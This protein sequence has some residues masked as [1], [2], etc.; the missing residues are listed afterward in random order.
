[1]EVGGRRPGPRATGAALAT[2]PAPLMWDARTD[3]RTGEPLTVRRAMA[4]IAPRAKRTAKPKSPSDGAGAQLT[5]TG[6][7]DFLAAPDTQYPVVVDPQINPLS[8]TFDTYVKQGDTTDN[9]AA[10]DLELGLLGTAVTRS[11]V[12]WDTSKLAGKQ[13]TSATVNF[14]NWWSQS[15]TASSWEIWSTG[16]ASADTR[17]SNQPAW[18]TREATSTGTKGGSSCT[19]GWVSVSGTSFFQRAATAGQSR[20]YMGI[21]ATSET[22]GDSFKQFRSRNAADSSQVPYAVVTYNSYPVVASRSTSPASNCAT[23][24]ARPY[25]ASATPTLKATLTDADASAVKGA[26]EWY[27]VGGVKIGG[28]TT[29]SAA[30]G[31]T[32]IAAVPSGAFANGSSYSWRVQANDGTVGGP[33]SSSCEFTID[34]SVPAVAPTVSSTTYPAGD[35]GGAAGTQGSFT[36][37][38]NGATDVAAYLYG[39]DTNPPATAVNATTLGGD[40]SV[41]ITPAT[42][43]SH[44]LYVRSRDRAGNLSPIYAYA[45]TVDAKVGDITSPESG[46]I[47]AG[48]TLLT[49]AAGT[50]STGVTYQWRRAETD[51]WTT[52]PAA[53]VTT[54]A[55][56]AVSWPVATTG[57]GKFPSLVWNLESTV[58]AAEAGP[59]ALDG[60]LQVRASYTGGIAGYAPAIRFSLDRDHANAAI[61]NVGPGSVNLLTGDLSVSVS[62]AEFGVGLGLQRTY[63]TRQPGQTDAMFGPGWT[64]TTVV[65]SADTYGTSSVTGSLV[66]VTVPGGST[67]GFTK[68]AVTSTGATFDPQVGNEDLSLEYRSAD[69]SYRLSDDSGTTVFTRK[70][71]DPAGVY[72]PT[73]AIALGNGDTTATSWE[74][75]T[76]DGVDVIRPTRIVDPAPTG[77]D[78]AASPLTTAGCRTLTFSYATATAGDDR[79]GRLSKVE[80]IAWD[81]ATNAMHTVTVAQYAYDTDGRL[82]AEWDPRLDYTDGSGAT[83]HQSTS[84]GYN[85]DGI[86]STITPPG[87]QPWTFAYTTIPGDAGKGRV[88]TVSRSAL[89]AGTSATTVV[90]HVPVAGAGAPGD[91]SAAQ[92]AR[93]GQT[94]V[95]VDAT[96]LFPPTQ[97]P[98]GDQAA[99]ALPSDWRQATV[100]YLD[101]NAR[102]TN[103]VNPGGHLTTTWY[104]QYGNIVRELTANDREVALNADTTDTPAAEAT[105][106]ETLSTETTYSDDGRLVLDELGPEHDVKLAN[107]FGS[108]RGRT[109]TTY[110]YGEGAPEGSSGQNALTTK[111]ESVRYWD[112]SGQAVDKDVRKTVTAYNWNLLQPTSTT[113]D[114]DGVVLTTRYTYDSA[115]RQDSSTTP[116]GDGTTAATRT[117][118]FYQAGTGS[119][120]DQCDNHP[121]W[122]DMVCRSG[123]A[124]QPDNDPE[125]PSQIT[126]YN[127]YGQPTTITERNSAGVLRTDTLG[128]DVAGRPPPPSQAARQPARR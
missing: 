33:W 2:I 13:I 118:V 10:N 62:D 7:P 60:P 19:D 24:S 52:I 81:P 18:N 112:S 36:F 93:W 120:Y 46:A 57:D 106:A 11:F 64:S 104:D 68:K 12:H 94:V 21:R 100:H 61:E 16:P 59:N 75:A 72:A 56:A 55:G 88:A 14:W 47:S 85:T 32:V 37:G 84:Y 54:A 8:T 73:S 90:Y 116:A 99:G 39:L 49:S 119:G 70:T 108:V 125:L 51:S 86:L 30:S 38:A 127:M 31:S 122:A 124:A 121:E 6:D 114:P 67:V 1:M 76:V 91:L 23:G 117:T 63:H 34:T 115:G 44:I 109:H 98:S 5:V 3:P 43:G 77:V 110:T 45:F 79:A 87:E 83:Q 42:A 35:S 80:F 128:Y 28:V 71:T 40:A 58:N 9:S 107:G 101:A 65:S 26:F 82:S 105:L 111:A 22:D 92:L 69:D 95:P 126:E 78:C 66:Q 50:T 17:W 29:A 4:K 53:D 41:S 113:V 103:V 20:G 74:K 97:I 96:A 27:A 15:C 89:S 25:I 102:E 48:K 123:P